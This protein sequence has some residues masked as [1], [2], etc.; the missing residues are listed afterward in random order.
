M[1]IKTCRYG[2]LAGSFMVLVTLG[3]C[4]AG[5][6]PDAFVIPV[7]KTEIKKQR[8]D[9]I[10][11]SISR[12]VLPSYARST[13]IMTRDADGSISESRKERWASPATEAVTRVLSIQIEQASDGVVLRRPLPVAYDAEVRVSILFD[14]FLRETSGGVDISG[15]F[16]IEGTGRVTEIR[17]FAISGKL[18]GDGEDYPSLVSQSLGLIATQISALL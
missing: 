13:A 6:T 1:S 15:K 3:A 7:T 14:S 18:E 5:P 12:V 2:R 8:E 4:G 16:V 11:I 17:N 10:Q 9:A